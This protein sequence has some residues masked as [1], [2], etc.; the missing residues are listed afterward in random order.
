MDGQDNILCIVLLW[1]SPVGDYFYF[2]SRGPN[3]KFSIVS[4]SLIIRKKPCQVSFNSF[5]WPE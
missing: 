2:D 3:F 4:S 1:Q 5:G